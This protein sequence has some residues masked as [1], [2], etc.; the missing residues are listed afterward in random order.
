MYQFNVLNFYA[1]KTQNY[2]KVGVPSPMTSSP[3]LWSIKWFLVEVQYVV[4][5]PW[6]AGW[7]LLWRLE[8]SKIAYQERDFNPFLL[9]QMA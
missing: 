3:G 4:I 2:S 7:L 8:I 1:I 6:L 5:L 9:F